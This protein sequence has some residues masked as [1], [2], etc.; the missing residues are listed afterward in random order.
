MADAIR[1]GTHDDIT[2][3]DRKEDIKHRLMLSLR[4]ALNGKEN[5]IHRTIEVFLGTVVREPVMG[6]LDAA[7]EV[8]FRRSH[9]GLRPKG[10]FQR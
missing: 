9:R 5:T 8:L 1:G 7:R 6:E 10:I 2:T 3:A 4:A